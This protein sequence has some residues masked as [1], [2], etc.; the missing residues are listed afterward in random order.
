[1]KYM[2]HISIG[3]IIIGVGLLCLG[4]LQSAQASSVSKIAYPNTEQGTLQDPALSISSNNQTPE[5]VI[6]SL[7]PEPFQIPETGKSVSNADIQKNMPREA[8]GQKISLLEIDQTL[9]V[10]KLIPDRIVIPVIRLDAPVEPAVL[11]RVSVSGYSFDQWV[12]PARFA[13]GWHQNSAGLGEIGNTVISGHHNDYGEVFKRLVDL[14]VGNLLYLYAQQNVFTYS[15]NNILLLKEKD[16]PLRQRIENA[17]WIGATKD[18]RITLVTC[19]PYES[20][21][22]RLIIVASPVR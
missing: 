2:V 9:K 19:W 1:M 20:N 4:V 13:A 5:D 17:K 16:V 6:P 8:S 22:H 15:V 21:S 14:K 3:M 12:A 10:G 7:L 11:M 18:E